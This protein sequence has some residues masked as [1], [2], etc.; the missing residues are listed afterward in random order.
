VT[1]GEA[2]SA[3][4]LARQEGLSYGLAWRGN[5]TVIAAADWFGFRAINVIDVAS[6][7]ARL[8]GARGARFPDAGPHGEVVWEN[9][10][11]GSNLWP[12]DARG[13]VADK[14]LWRSTRYTTQPAFS[15]DGKR[16][17]FASNRDGV[18]AIYVAALDGEPRRVAFGENQRYLRPHWSSDGRSI[19]A[20]RS[21]L[22]LGAGVQEAV[23]IPVDG[24]PAEI[25]A[26][27]GHTV[28]DVRE[29]GDGKLYWGE[30]SS[31]A[32]RLM[33]APLGDLA[34][35]ERLPTPLVSNYQI[36][37]G[38]LVYAQPQLP[39][40]TLCRLDTLACEPLG[41]DISEVDVYHWLLARRSVYLRHREDDNARLARFD[42]A[43][44]RIAQHWDL[45]PSGAGASIAVSPD[46]SQLLVA[47]EEGP[48]ID[49]MIAR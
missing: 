14:P 17:L 29:G 6:G 31:H 7:Q 35:P 15:P 10:V 2:G 1:R 48:A 25:L 27:L 30:L 20:I 47:R 8:A 33:R 11:Y 21:A 42:L 39:G 26:P 38:R 13:K 41:L 32:M 18:D 36:D 34:H 49:L 23:R 40:L 3:H 12:M 22:S 19:Y 5:D 46:E 4:V 45:T 37:S 9:A 24:G 28:N 16:V 43:T 44:R